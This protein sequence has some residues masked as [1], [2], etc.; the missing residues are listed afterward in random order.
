METPIISLKKVTKRYKHFSALEEITLN[1]NPCEITGIIGP[2][3]S[4]KSS[5]LKICSG[6]LSF[7][8]NATF[9][10]IDLS[11]NPESIKSHISFMPQGIGL[12]LYMDLSV[13]ENINFFAEVKAVPPVKRDPLKKRLLDI[14]GL[15]P[16]RE[17][18]AKHLSGGMKQKLGICCSLIS[19]PEVLLLDEPS[20]GVDPLSRRQLWELLNSFISETGTTLVLATSYMDEA[21]RCHTITFLHKG[22]IIFSGHPEQLMG[23]EKDLEE[24]FF[25]MLLE[26]KELPPFEIPFE[27]K[28]SVNSR[29]AIK[30]E[31]LSKYFNSFKAVDN[32]SLSIR[33]GEIFG[34]LGPNGAGKTT[35]LKCILALLKIDGGSINVLGMPAGSP[36]LK[37]WIGYMSQIFSLYGDLTVKENIE[38]YGTLYEIEKKAL[39][40]RMNWVINVSNLK[41]MENAIVKKLP[42]GIKQ[43]L[44]LG[45]ATLNLPSILILDE[46][47]SGVDPVA[48]KS[49]WQLIGGLSD[50][51][52]MT[53][54]VTTHN[55][56]EADYCERIAI[57]NEGKVIAIDTPENLRKEFV[58]FH[59][60][61]YELYP[62]KQ[63]D[64]ETFSAREISIT[65]FGRRYHLWKKG[66]TEVEIKTLSDAHKIGYRYIR[67]IRPPMEDVF[68][69]FLEKK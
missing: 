35:L 17:R 50:K 12:N 14:T 8:G 33:E 1:V 63:I 66:L 59:G 11:K 39:K 10:D 18:Y 4:G 55:L 62:D 42:L 25:E 6:V 27:K 30:I 60:D 13:E 34:F 16:F 37:Q 52:G 15:A 20:T 58:D 65:P 36:E 32:V 23:P 19:K 26:G 56:V 68:I 3:G 38:L 40:E 48:R 41:G 31:G 51:L 43:R 61:V 24:A 7:Q 2:D 46:P 21:E 28:V 29:T 57:M 5:L 69:Y 44:A 9:M 53:V 54:I 47:T 22:K 49:F 64:T 67:K 45:C